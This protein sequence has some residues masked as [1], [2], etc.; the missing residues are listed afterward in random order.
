MKTCER[1]K[2]SIGAWMDGE[3][4]QSDAEEVR[5]H[6]EDCPDCAAER[7]QLEKLQLSLKRLLES[8]ASR[9]QLEPL[10]REVERRMSRRPV[11][12]GAA[13]EWVRPAF[14]ASRLSWAVPAII[15]CLLIAVSLESFFPAWRSGARR[16][17]FAAVDSIDTYGRNVALLR[18]YETKTTVIW[19][20]QNQEGENESTG[21]TGEPGPSF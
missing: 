1:V 13:W 7:R 4:K 10:W 3:L 20:Y 2:L 8:E 16:N 15:A 19:L 12:Y 9:L 11:W 21:E 17:N 6:L 18:E 5:R 14:A